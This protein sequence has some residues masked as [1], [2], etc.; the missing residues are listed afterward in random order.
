MHN[1]TATALHQMNRHH[2]DRRTRFRFAQGD[3]NWNASFVGC[4]P[5]ATCPSEANRGNLSRPDTEERIHGEFQ[6]L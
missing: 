2:L 5:S 6:T 4:T 1:I 3:N